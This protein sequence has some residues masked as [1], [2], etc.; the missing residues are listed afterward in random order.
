MYFMNYANYASYKP[1]PPKTYTFDINCFNDMGHFNYGP[2][3]VPNIVS[4]YIFD[5][6]YKNYI[7][8]YTIYH[9]KEKISTM[10]YKLK[11]GLNKNHTYKFIHNNDTYIINMKYEL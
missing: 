9:P 8:S 4:R 6:I 3:N 7:S 1:E 5:H 11:D 10:H 2:W